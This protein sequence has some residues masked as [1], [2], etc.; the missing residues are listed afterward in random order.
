MAGKRHFYEQRRRDATHFTATSERPVALIA[1]A[2]QA[3]GVLFAATASADNVDREKLAGS[4]EIQ[5]TAPES[6]AVT[7]W[8]FKLQG[9]S[10]H[11]TEREGD[12]AVA[13]FECNTEGTP[14]EV[15]T[16]GKKATISMWFNGPKLVQMETKGSDVV[17]RRFGILPKGDV[18]EMEL[19]PIVPSG[20]SETYQ[21]KR[22]ASGDSR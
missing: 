21:Y 15:K 12:K 1:I 8:T 11:V 17:K 5:G 13:N 3:I 7:G 6:N 19:I 4:W 2:L 14:C 10:F 20:K 18:L 22:I 16:G 9:N